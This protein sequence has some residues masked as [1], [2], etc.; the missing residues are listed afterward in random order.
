MGWDLSNFQKISRSKGLP[1]SSV[2]CKALFYKYSKALILTDKYKETWKNFWASYSQISNEQP[3]LNAFIQAQLESETYIEASLQN[4]HS[5]AD[6]LCQIINVVL[7][8]STL[9]EAKVDV[10]TTIQELN[11]RNLDRVKIALENLCNSHEFKYISAFVNTIKHRRLLDTDYHGEFGLGMANN[12]D[13]RFEAFTYDKPNKPIESYPVI[14]AST[15][16]E[17][18]MPNIQAL[19]DSLGMAIEESI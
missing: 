8:R 13:I 6:I 2:Y 7:F 16:I 1:D 12:M 4:L 19:I 15:I 9:H 17:E 11:N 3:Y 10:R 5:I 18:Y 14:L